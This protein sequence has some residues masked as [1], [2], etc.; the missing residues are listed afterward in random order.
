VTGQSGW[1]EWLRRRTPVELLGE[2]RVFF[3]WVAIALS[4]LLVAFVGVWNANRYP[5]SLGYDVSEH[6][7]YAHEVLHNHRLPTAATHGEYNTP[8]AYYVVAGLA[9]S[10]G[11]RVF[12]WHEAKFLYQPDVSYRGAQYLNVLLDLLTAL[13]ILWLAVRIAPRSPGVW[14]GAVGFF[15]ILP[16]VAKTG[17]MFHPENL[18]MASSAAA[19]AAATDLLV[20]RRFRRSVIA[21]LIVAI[22]VGMLT[23]TSAM[24]TAAA[25]LIGLA[26]VGLSSDLRHRLPWR[27][28]GVV[29]IAVLTL[30]VS[31]I[32][33]Q[34]LVQHQQPFGNGR[35]SLAAALHPGSA[36]DPATRSHFFDLS[37][38][39]VFKTPYRPT[40][41]GE[42]VTQNYI[43]T[44]GDWYGSFAWS[45]YSI[46][47]RPEALVV[48]K[49][50]EWI[51][52]LP[53]LAALAGLVLLLVLALW[54]RRELLPLA[55][56]TPIAIAGYLYRSYA[57]MSPDA[58]VL[59]PIY[60]LA[61]TPAWAIGFGLVA[62]WLGG[63]STF[64]RVGIV[65]LL[66]VFAVIEL[67][68]TMY[69]LRDHRPIF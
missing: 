37:V 30:A 5:I 27:R 69:G 19:V 48:L 62:G 12:G 11:H 17:A 21:V 67:R 51:G 65:C 13:C 26:V 22:L 52:V 24:F 3:A 55:L 33:W 43:D 47:P 42:A 32:G 40:A 64:A 44:W 36:G 68:F 60:I 18:N 20:T 66:V 58:D 63:R 45:S 15:A 10:L 4:L 41:L 49:D 50:Q 35:G 38:S 57:V 31:W 9:A 23:R 29:L 7:A 34:T 46:T 56:L 1:P 25:I 14:A 54:R 6:T 16:I 61:T 2:P 8:P 39:S 53:T 59:K 28:I